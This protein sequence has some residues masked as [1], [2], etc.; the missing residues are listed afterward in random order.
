MRKDIWKILFH[1]EE[2]SP[3]IICI[4]FKEDISQRRGSREVIKSDPIEVVKF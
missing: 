2:N 1:S 3:S 4:S